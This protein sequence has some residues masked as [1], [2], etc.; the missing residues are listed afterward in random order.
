MLGQPGPE[1][2]TEGASPLQ[3]LGTALAALLVLGSGYWLWQNGAG[4]F[5]SA[6]SAIAEAPVDEQANAANAAASAA[7]SAAAVTAQTR[8]SYVIDGARVFSQDTITL[9]DGQFEALNVESGPQVVV[10]S[11]PSLGKASVEEYALRIANQWSIGDSARKDGVLLLVAPNDRK[12][13]IEVGKGLQRVLT[14]ADCQRLIDDVMVPLFRKG[15]YDAG[16]IAA[17]QALVTKLKANPTLPG[18]SPK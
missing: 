17:S 16:V 10:M 4:T 11:V 13:R 12:V 14:N 6:G 18:R 5:N 15:Q 2:I 1:P 8:S 7:A 3:L 9:L